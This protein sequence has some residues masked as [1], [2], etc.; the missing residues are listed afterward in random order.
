[1]T[2][3][4][5]FGNTK[6]IFF[7]WFSLVDLII[8]LSILVCFIIDI[9]LKIIIIKKAYI[10]KIILEEYE[11]GLIE[12]KKNET[13]LFS[14]LTCLS[15]F[16]IIATI[17][18]NLEIYEK[19][20]FILFIPIYLLFLVYCIINYTRYNKFKAYV[21]K[22]L[23]CSALK[24]FLL[25]TVMLFINILLITIFVSFFNLNSNLLFLPNSINAL[26][27]IFISI[28]FN[29]PFFINFTKIKNNIK[30]IAK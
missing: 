13:A 25:E 28:A 14:F 27:I 4:L 23:N 19:A 21:P 17:F 16:I 2:I 29:L 24:P 11:K 20:N 18:F 1:M 26:T 6:S 5:Y 8:I 10:Y 30:I 3:N 22:I 15:V 12:V 9:T 7:K